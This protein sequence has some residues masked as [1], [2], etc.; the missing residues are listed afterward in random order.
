MRCYDERP[1]EEEEVEVTEMEQ[2]RGSFPALSGLAAGEVRNKFGP[3]I[4]HV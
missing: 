1:K 3:E 4:K 2:S